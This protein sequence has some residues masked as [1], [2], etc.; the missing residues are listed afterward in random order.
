MGFECCGHYKGED[1][2][3]Y[4]AMKCGSKKIAS[5]HRGMCKVPWRKRVKELQGIVS[6]PVEFHS[7]CNAV[8]NLFRFGAEGKNGLSFLVTCAIFHQVPLLSSYN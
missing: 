3:V 4:G 2:D 8:S 1:E 6:F 5:E 7:W